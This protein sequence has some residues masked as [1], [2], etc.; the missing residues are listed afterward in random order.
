MNLAFGVGVLGTSGKWKRDLG[1]SLGSENRGWA[2]GR[3]PGQ[4]L[5]VASVRGTGISSVTLVNRQSGVRRVIPALV[6]QTFLFLAEDMTARIAL[7]GI[8]IILSGVIGTLLVG[9]LIS[10]NLQ[11]FEEEYQESRRRKFGKDGQDLGPR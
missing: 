1:V 9:F 8:G 10:R 2:N 5:V 7:G 6:N 4:T 3:K 11:G